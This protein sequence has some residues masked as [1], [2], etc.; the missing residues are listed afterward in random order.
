ME[1]PCPGGFSLLLRVA[2]LQTAGFV[3]LQPREDLAVKVVEAEPSALVR[4]VRS[5]GPALTSYKIAA[6]EINIVLE[7]V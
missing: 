2:G 7:A 5:H 4:G 1:F 6:I 3:R